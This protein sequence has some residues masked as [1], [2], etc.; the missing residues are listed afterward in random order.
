M[1]TAPDLGPAVYGWDE[2]QRWTLA[3]V[4]T[5]IGLLFYIRHTLRSMS[6]LL[7]RFAPGNSAYAR[8]GIWD[9]HY[10]TDSRRCSCKRAR[11]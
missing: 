11:Q 10:L 1:R 7:H 9:P 3:R 5:L 8:Y 2:G 4:A 6:C